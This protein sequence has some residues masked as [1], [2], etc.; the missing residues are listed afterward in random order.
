MKGNWFSSERAPRATEK[1][2]ENSRRAANPRV[3]FSIV[4]EFNLL[5]QHLSEAGE[6]Q[7]L[8]EGKGKQK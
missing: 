6:A 7:K 3:A 5:F 8:T 2:E 1:Q 4:E